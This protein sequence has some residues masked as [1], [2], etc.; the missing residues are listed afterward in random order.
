MVHVPAASVVTVLPTTVQMA[1]VS[2]RNA[3]T[4]PELAAADTP[5]EAPTLR[6][7]SGPNLIV[8]GVSELTIWMLWVTCGAAAYPEPPAC[9]A[10]MVQVPVP[11][12]VTVLP[13][14]EQ[15]AESDANDTVSPE[16]AEAATVNVPT[17][18]LEGGANA[19]VCGVSELTIWMLWVTCGAAKYPEPPACDAVMVQGPVPVAVTVVPV[20][21][22]MAASDANDTVSPE[23]AVAAIVNVPTGALGGGA[24]VIVCDSP[25]VAETSVEG[26]L[27]L[28]LMALTT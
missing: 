15:M 5:K 20:T 14:T 23:L 3:T 21:V 4:S 16:L 18:S 8:C 6:P 1:G 26:W 7:L 24:K 10:V 9:V 17:R 11:V 12:A 28:P 25:G 13:V 2:D 27:V 19:I 22:Q